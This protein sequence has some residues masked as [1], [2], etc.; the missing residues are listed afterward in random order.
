[1]RGGFFLS[2]HYLLLLQAF[3]RKPKKTG[4]VWPSSKFLAQK[5]V[6]PVAWNEPSFSP[7]NTVA[8]H[9]RKIR[10]KIEI[11]PKEPK[12]LKAVWGKKQ[13]ITN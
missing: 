8:V 1:M 9:I 11:N 6:G 12:Y 4:S 10:E 13:S 2:N 3:I 7:E 5:M